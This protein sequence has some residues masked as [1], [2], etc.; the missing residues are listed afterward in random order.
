MNNV[1]RGITL[2]LGIK[3]AYFRIAGYIGNYDLGLELYSGYTS[4]C[5]MSSFYL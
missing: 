2:I 5:G 4:K 1:N 3:L